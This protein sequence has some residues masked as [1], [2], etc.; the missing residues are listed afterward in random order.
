VSRSGADAGTHRHPG[1]PGL[2]RLVRAGVLP[3]ERAAALDWVAG[4]HAV[5]VTPALCALIDPADPADPVARQYV[6]DAAELVE[7]PEECG[8]PIG[9]AAHMPVAGLVHRYPD[10]VL[11]MATASC[12][13]YC[14][15][16]FRR[17]RV[18]TGDAAPG[19]A[20]LDACLDYIR[21]R[22]DIWEVILSGGD[23]LVLAPRRLGALIA[24]LDAIGHVGVV[25]VHTRL[26]VADPERVTPAL[27]GA[28]ATADSALWLAVHVNHPRELTA[29]AL[30]AI[31]RLIDAG[32]ALVSQTVLLR[33]VNDD[34]AV[35][36]A[37][38]RA[39]VR[40]RVK[41]YYLHHADLAPGT[42]HFRTGIEEGRA[43]MRALRGR[44][45][46]L[47]QP[48]YVLDLPGGHG[49]VPAGPG[50]LEGC[51]AAG[52]R[53]EAPGG[54]THRYPPGEDR[55]SRADEAG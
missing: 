16:C 54:G 51:D 49:K 45:S 26:P 19:P 53:A 55:V 48:T 28:L 8:D 30:A 6:P 22:P 33:G 29:A 7:R 36:E 2:A 1:D 34:P 50:W 11:L 47:C 25:R 37:L 15:F 46:G 44:V 23:P 39:L 35:L 14:R 31:R 40:A 27:A 18:G 52:W 43:L 32:A 24:A 3:P 10:R 42:G 4:R 12:A 38:F 21:A 20:E 13:A 9:D 17:T 41:P 5:A